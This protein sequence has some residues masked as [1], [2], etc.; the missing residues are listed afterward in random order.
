[1]IRPPPRSTRT[2]TLFPYTTLCRSA[3]YLVAHPGLDREARGGTPGSGQ[4]EFGAILLDPHI[5]GGERH[6]DAVLGERDMAV[7]DVE[8][9]LCA[10]V[11][12]Q[13]LAAAAQ[14]AAQDR[15]AGGRVGGI[16]LVQP[17]LAGGVDA[18]QAVVA[19][20]REQFEPAARAAALIIFH[21]RLGRPGVVA[22]GREDQDRKST[23]LN[24]SH[25]C[26]S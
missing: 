6:V 25:S 14:H 17:V 18:V 10:E 23:R 1:M 26:A 3:R 5:V 20:D 7:E 15:L 9:A 24:S 8:R 11:D 16:D 13:Q 19:A 21:L 22:L 2:D 4:E 12:R